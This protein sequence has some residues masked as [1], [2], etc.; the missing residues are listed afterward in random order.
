MSNDNELESHSENRLRHRRYA[1][2]SNPLKEFSS[3]AA[4]TFALVAALFVILIAS[5]LVLAGIAGMVWLFSANVYQLSTTGE[6]IL[7]FWLFIFMLYCIHKAQVFTAL[8]TDFSGNKE[9]QS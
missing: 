2:S 6:Y 4:T 7:G 3:N 8:T 5:P 1:E 9:K